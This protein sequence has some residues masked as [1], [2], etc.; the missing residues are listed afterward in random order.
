MITQH[1]DNLLK[2]LIIFIDQVNNDP[3]H[4][5]FSS[6]LLTAIINV[7]ATRAL[8]AILFLPESLYK[9]PFLSMKYKNKKA[10]MRL[11]PSVKV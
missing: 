3:D 5:I 10:A 7:K 2:E 6:C 1:N 4:S 8:S 9:I 11:F